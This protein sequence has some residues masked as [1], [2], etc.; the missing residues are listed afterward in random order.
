MLMNTGGLRKESDRTPTELRRNSDGVKR[1]DSDK[2]VMIPTNSAEFRQ[3]FYD[4]DKLF[5]IPSE[6]RRNSVGIRRS[7][8]ESVGFDQFVG[9]AHAFVGVDKKAQIRWCP[10]GIRR[11]PIGIRRNPTESDGI[12]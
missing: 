9:I 7:P 3:I 12:R 2:I 6:F 5:M 8:S 10:T 4:S 1:I 11:N